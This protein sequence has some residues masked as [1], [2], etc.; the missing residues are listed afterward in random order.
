MKN[1]SAIFV[2]CITLMQNFVVSGHFLQLQCSFPHLLLNMVQILH[3]FGNVPR[4][5]L[6]QAWFHQ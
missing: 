1:Y 6:L 2:F 4:L 5:F 3:T